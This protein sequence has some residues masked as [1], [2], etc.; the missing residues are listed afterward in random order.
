MQLRKIKVGVVQAT[1]ALFN[2]EK[3]VEIVISWIKK[4]VDEGCEMLLFPE[5]F[6]PC[7]PRGINFDATVGRRTD[8][9]SSSLASSE[10]YF[11]SVPD[12]ESV[13]SARLDISKIH[14]NQ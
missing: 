6:I 3:T 5:S 7:Y 14:G 13:N 10:I 12:L 2:I 8:K 4:G 11:S 9:S 1:P